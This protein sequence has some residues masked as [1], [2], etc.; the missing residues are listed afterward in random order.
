MPI[1]VKPRVDQELLYSRLKA[2][3]QQSEK[4]LREN[5]PES[6][7]FLDRLNLRPGKIREHATKLLTSG[8][9]S[10]SL[11]LSSHS[12]VPLP[13]L[14]SLRPSDSVKKNVAN[15]TVPGELHRQLIEKLKLILPP[16]GEWKLNIKQESEIS[17]FLLQLYGIRSTVELEGN[18]LN[19]AYGRMGAEQHLPRFPGDS[20]YQH[21]ELTEKGITP[22]RGAWGYFANSK[23]ELT[24]ELRETEKWY[25]AVQT[26]Y[27][28]NWNTDTKR[29]SEWYKYRRVV[30]INPANGRVVIA[31]VADAGPA[32]WT[33]KHFGGSPEVMKYLQIDYGMQNHPVLVMFLDDPEKKVPLGPME[34]NVD[35]RQN[36]LSERG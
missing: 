16:V 29:L 36:Y 25:V 13:L 26:L 10:G 24:L 15:L 2:K 34:F 6:S 30:V 31:A 20:V 23:N 32:S 22:G 1:S 8:V 3:S 9:L 12:L 4:R 18:R 11:L 28:P 17:Q 5:H 21:D 27:L 33:G 35:E 7:D 19:H 14:S